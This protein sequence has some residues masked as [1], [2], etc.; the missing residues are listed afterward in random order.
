MPGKQGYPGDTAL[1]LGGHYVLARS[2]N[3][4]LLNQAGRAKKLVPDLVFRCSDYSTD[5]EAVQAAIDALP[6]A[7][8][9]VVLSEGVFTLAASLLIA[10]GRPL[11]LVGQGRGITTLIL[12][13]DV[14]DHIIKPAGA[15]TGCKFEDFTLDGNKDNQS[16]GAG[17]SYDDMVHVT[18]FRVEA[19]NCKA[20]GFGG[21]TSHTITDGLWIDCL[22][23]DND[24][25]GFIIGLTSDRCRLIVCTAEDNGSLGIA[26]DGC[27]D[28]MVLACTSLGNTDDGIEI[29]S[30]TRNKVI[31]CTSLNN[32]SKGI[33]VATGGTDVLIADN[34]VNGN[35]GLGIDRGI[36][37]STVVRNN[38]GHVTEKSGTATLVNGQTSIAVTHGLAVTPVAGDIM[39][40]PIESWGNAL[41]FWIS[42]YS[43]TTFTITVDQ[44]P[45]ADVDFA[46]KAIV[47]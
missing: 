47:L 42:A 34:I 35:S 20:A 3:S 9:K 14:D 24:T 5:D 46:W 10:T 15:V 2:A 32:G 25:F 7:G 13:D 39:V 18:T 33:D 23:H 12:A 31:G 29:F 6:G 40:T 22:A 44:D 38:I 37:S 36:S 4:D 17:I 45:G 43:S 41:K 26:L 1:A 30:A 16:A 21:A 11:T 8:G 19:K 28:S 27:V